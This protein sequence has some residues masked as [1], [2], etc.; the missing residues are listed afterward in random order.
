MQT[1]VT[2]LGTAGGPGGKANAAGIATLIT[3]GTHRYLVDG[4]EGVSRQLAMS[5]VRETAIDRVFITHLHDDHTAGIPSLVTFAHTTRLEI[6]P[7]GDP[8]MQIIGPPTR[9]KRA[10]RRGIRPERYMR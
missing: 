4:G 1:T 8:K 6:P 5:G 9:P 10:S 7:S 3:V 2:L